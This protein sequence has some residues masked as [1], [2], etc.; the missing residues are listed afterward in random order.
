MRRSTIL[1]CVVLRLGGFFRWFTFE[2]SNITET[3][4]YP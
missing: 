4:E 2:L 1:D 3:A